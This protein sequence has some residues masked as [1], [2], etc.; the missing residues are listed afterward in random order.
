MRWSWSKPKW[1]E[2]RQQDVEKWLQENKWWVQWLVFLTVSLFIFRT[3]KADNW[4]KWTG[5]QDK[6]LWEWLKLF[7]VPLSVAALGYLLQSQQRKQAESAARTQR[8]IASE[9]EKEEILQTY[10]DRLSALLIDKNI[11]AIAVQVHTDT[12]SLAENVT[13]AD[14]ELLDAAIDVIRAR[15]LSILR[16]FDNDG[17]RKGSVIRFLAEAEVL[18]KGRL[19]LRK[20][21]LSLAK[22]SLTDL[23]DANL[24]CTNLSGAD[25]S[26]ANLNRTNF[27]EAD[28]S[29]AVLLASDFRNSKDIS[30]DQLSGK[31]QPYLCNIALPDTITDVNPNRDC[32]KIPKLIS[33]RY[34]YSSEQAK[35]IVNKAREKTW[36]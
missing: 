19:S 4:A 36:N 29:N 3:S 22:L 15:T 34:G 2:Q 32:G 21:N 27:I 18:S 23:S 12:E 11:L 9:E 35:Q 28:L 14:K 1:L 17:E 13:L 5:F 16:R 10:F 7:G 33:D 25:L 31:N 6:T 8:Q 24:S 30:A 20:A 26:N